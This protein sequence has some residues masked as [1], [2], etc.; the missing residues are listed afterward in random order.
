MVSTTDGGE[1]TGDV[2]GVAAGVEGGGSGGVGG[3]GWVK[4]GREVEEL[5]LR[6]WWLMGRGD[7]KG[8]EV[9]FRGRGRRRGGG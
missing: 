2:G 8:I 6:W 7:G 4:L 5:E 1:A 9:I 3:G